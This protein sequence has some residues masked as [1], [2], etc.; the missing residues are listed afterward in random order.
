MAKFESFLIEHDDLHELELKILR[1]AH[2]YS[3]QREFDIIKSANKDVYP[4]IEEIENQLRTSLDEFTELKAIAYLNNHSDFYKFI[5]I[6]EQLRCQMRWSQTPR[7]PETSV[8]GHSMY[9]ATLSFFLSCEIKVCKKTLVNNFYTALFHDLPESVT[10]DIISPVKRATTTLPQVI[11]EIEHSVCTNKLYPKVPEGIRQDLR[12]LLG[13]IQ[14]PDIDE[15][16]DRIIDD[17]KVVKLEGNRKP[18][19]YNE[20][21]WERIDGQL[22]K[23]CDE[24]AAF[25]EAFKSIE[26]G[27]SSHHLQEGITHV[28]NK[29]MNKEP[30]MGISANEFFIEFD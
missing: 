16:T 24:V 23:L 17:G 8:L 10:R 14:D 29:Y 18:Q 25:M 7:I 9:V 19:D 12:Y 26:H 27:I 2:K 11:K 28:R 3:T 5:C 21:K 30:M 6:V 4:E 15:F 13:D 1:A 20:D 22:I